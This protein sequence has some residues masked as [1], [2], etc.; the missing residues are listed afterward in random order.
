VVRHTDGL[1]HV[2]G[3]G[4]TFATFEDGDHDRLVAFSAA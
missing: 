4:A 3:I 1:E 2:D